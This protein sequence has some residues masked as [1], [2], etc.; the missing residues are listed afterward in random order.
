[1]RTALD[2]ETMH[3]AHAINKYS[4]EFYKLDKESASLEHKMHRYHLDPRD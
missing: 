4:I 2:T 3:Q 1:M